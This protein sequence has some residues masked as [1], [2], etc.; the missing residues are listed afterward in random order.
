MNYQPRGTQIDLI[1][2]TAPVLVVRGGAGT[3]KTTTAV[4][5]ARAHLDSADRQ[6]QKARRAVALS[7]QR[8][9]LPASQRA[10]FLSFSRTAVTQILDRAG[11]VIGPSR[12]RLEVSTFHGFAWRII[13]DFGAH[14]GYPRPLAIISA[15]NS[16][17][18]GAPPGLT[19]DQLLPSASALL[20][21]PKIADHYA[22]RYGIVICDEFQDTD[23]GEW[24]FLQTIAPAA[25]RILL[26]DANQCIYGGFK[27]GV[28]PAGRRVAALAIPGATAIDLPAVSHR[29]PTGVLPA[30][31]DAARRRRFD[32]PTIHAAASS[33]RLAVTRFQEGNGYREVIALTRDARK[34]GHTVS[35]FTHTIAATTALSD[36]LSKA[37]LAHEQVG[38]GEA[39][40]EALAAQLALIQYA[41]G[42]S[43]SL[44]RPLTVFLTACHGGRSLP[45]LA[46]Q[47]LSKSNPALERAIDRLAK[48]LATAGGTEPDVDRLTEVVAGAWARIGTSRGQ[49]TWREASKQTARTLRAAP[50]QMIATVSAE[51]LRG[52]NDALAGN[53]TTP[54]H[55]IEVMNLHQTKGREADTTILLLG[56]DEFHG[57]ESEPF[58]QGSRLLY[59]VMTR[60]RQRAHIV[61]PDVTHPLWQ[62]LV[63]ACETIQPRIDPPSQ[64]VTETDRQ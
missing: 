50:D 46:T 58:P 17:V 33:E 22:G 28:D 29:D 54:R 61:V 53:H 21:V 59:V 7:G 32:D 5:A 6:L 44:R 26:G 63:A 40:G 37:G 2:S 10:L 3:G 23:A 42:D 12:P 38:F 36:A 24:A 60:A 47:L 48:D 15:A 51:L 13:N 27:P 34:Q 16:K 1:T 64:C 35:I 56:S 39:Y 4:A 62:P 18:P 45:P 49:E 19:Y 52:R 57:K 14:H 30:A 20:A 31:A 9:R 55:R 8:T 25:R 41:L 43:K 11:S